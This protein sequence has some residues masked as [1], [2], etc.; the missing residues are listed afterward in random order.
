MVLQNAHV[1]SWRLRVREFAA[2]NADALTLCY[3]KHDSAELIDTMVLPVWTEEPT[4]WHDS[5]LGR[6]ERNA[7]LVHRLGNRSLS[8]LKNTGSNRGVFRME[9]YANR[10]RGREDR[11][12]KDIREER[13]QPLSRAIAGSANPFQ[14][15]GLADADK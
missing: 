5:L 15:Q 4:S 12:I 6:I 7:H 13:S 1:R 2:V 8:S 3:Q 14:P 10:I 9:R 11:V